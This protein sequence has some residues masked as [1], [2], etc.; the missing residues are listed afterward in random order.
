M[1]DEIRN[2]IDFFLRNITK[3]SR[4]NY[5]ETDDKLIKRNLLEN[6][7]TTDILNKYLSKNESLQI[8]I[9][10][11]GS[12][13]WFY[14]KGE[15]EY[16]KSFSKN[17]SIDGV[18]IDA[19]RLY[20]NL[21]SRFEVAKY[22]TKDL[23]NTHYIAD[24]LLNI[25][26]KYDYIIWILPFVTPEPLKYWGLPKRYYCPDKLLKHAYDL[27]NTNGQMLI[28]NQG[29]QEAQKQKDLLNSLRINH[30]ELGEVKSS[31]FEYAQKRFGFLVKKL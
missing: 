26:N 30:T 2:N 13:N 14:A 27:L 21:Y 19:Y 9:L 28:I 16:F 22:Y 31:Y 29:A 11:I 20:T 18:E 3:F 4:K 25:H 7:Y 17:F 1:F 15:Y 10:D 8:R 24:N 12:K 5:V 6:K 23:E